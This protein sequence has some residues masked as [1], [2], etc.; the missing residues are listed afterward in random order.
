M[1]FEFIKLYGFQAGHFEKVMEAYKET[2]KFPDPAS[3]PKV[4]KVGV[5]YNEINKSETEQKPKKV[6]QAKI[7]M[8]ILDKLQM[9]LLCAFVTFIVNYLQNNRIIGNY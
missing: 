8:N 6:V 1:G 9:V 7:S 4:E 3:V 2:G 5:F